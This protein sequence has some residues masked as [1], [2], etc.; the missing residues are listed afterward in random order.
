MNNACYCGK[1][2]GKQHI[3]QPIWSL[4]SV[5][6]QNKKY[7]CLK[8]S[9]KSTAVGGYYFPLAQVVDSGDLTAFSIWYE[10]GRK[11]QYSINLV[12]TSGKINFLEY[13]EKQGHTWTKAQIQ[14]A[15]SSDALES[16]KFMCEHGGEYDEEICYHAS[17]SN[18][19]KC[20][21]YLRSLLDK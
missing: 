10:H 9:L 15:A 1:C 16:L 13:L 2:P 7:D 21:Y 19:W 18:A 11:Q 6:V 5:I 14:T 3:P 12:I 17:N 8:E 20:V 4:L